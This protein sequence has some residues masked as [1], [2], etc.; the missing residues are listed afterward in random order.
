MNQ[1]L[2]SAM[3]WLCACLFALKEMALKTVVY[4]VAGDELPVP[5]PVDITI[6]GLTAQSCLRQSASL[7]R[8]T[9]VGTNRSL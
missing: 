9:G 4:E 2:A 7:C 5:M 8:D 1:S 6:H 3:R